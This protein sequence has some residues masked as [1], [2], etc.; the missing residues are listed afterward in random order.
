MA[1]DVHILASEGGSR[2][3]LTNDHR[4]GTRSGDRCSSI[5]GVYRVPGL[6]IV[7]HNASD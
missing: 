6:A 5:H 7:I 2:Q 4:S 1:M 3:Q